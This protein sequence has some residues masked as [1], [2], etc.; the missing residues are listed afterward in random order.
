[1]MFQLANIFLLYLSA[2]YANNIIFHFTL[3]EKYF[4]ADGIKLV[5]VANVIVFGVLSTE[6]I[7]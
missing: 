2:T 5:F 6:E 3:T 1:M 4:V 7:D